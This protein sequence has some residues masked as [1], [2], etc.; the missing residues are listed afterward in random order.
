MRRA[1]TLATSMDARRCGR[2]TKRSRCASSL[3]Y[4]LHGTLE[5]CHSRR[6]ARPST[7]PR[8]LHSSTPE[9]GFAAE[10]GPTT[11]ERGHRCFNMTQ[12][13]AEGS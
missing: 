1:S 13:Q 12:G 5:S 10:W 6:L 8:G 7:R 2:A 11:A 3:A 9:T 4:H